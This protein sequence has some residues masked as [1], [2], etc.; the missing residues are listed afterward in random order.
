MITN[1]FSVDVEDGISIAMRDL[2]GKNIK[3]TDR[4]VY[5]TQFILNLLNDKNI[6]GTFFCLGKV[7][8]KFPSLIREIA[9]SKH[10]LAVHGFSHTQYFKLS[11]NQ[12]FS[13]VSKSKKLIEDISGVEVFGHRAPAFSIGYNNR[14]V[15]DELAKAG[16][17]YDSSIMPC[18]TGRYGWHRFPENMCN[19]VTEKKNNIVEVPMSVGNLFLKKIPV[20]GGG[21]LRVMPYNL[22]D[23]YFKKISQNRP[24]I[25]YMHPY[26][27]DIEKYPEYFFDE[28]RNKSLLTNMKVR[29]N[30]IGRKLYRKK[31]SKFLECYHFEPLIE[32]IKKTKYPNYTVT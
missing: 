21:Y 10:E 17:K 27:I 13:E 20:C 9:T 1:C 4:V 18:E 16:Y 11:K 25:M 19:V 2:F 5:N 28:L 14:W 31:I 15:L 22:S 7:A 29:S 3:Q 12:I 26:E 23:Y 8:E 24:V 30:W 32:I 6:K